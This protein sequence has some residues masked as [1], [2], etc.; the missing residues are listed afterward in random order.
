MAFHEQIVSSRG[1]EVDGG[2]APLLEVL[3][4]R[5]FETLFSCEGATP[6]AKFGYISFQAPALQ[7]YRAVRALFAQFVEA[8]ELGVIKMR[9]ASAGTIEAAEHV[10]KRWRVHIELWDERPEVVTVR[11]HP[12]VLAKLT[13]WASDSV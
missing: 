13:K 10:A 8:Q 9:R 3:W 11:F 6:H 4:A 7:E 2:L 12:D 5:G 1:F